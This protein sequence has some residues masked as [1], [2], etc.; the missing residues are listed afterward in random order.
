MRLLREVR[1]RGA[2]HP[3]ILNCLQLAGGTQICK[4]LV[5]AGDKRVALLEQQAELLATGLSFELPNDLALG[6]F[7]GG[8]V[9]RGREVNDQPVNLAIL[10][11][12]LGIISVIEHLHIVIGLDHRIDELQAGGADLGSEVRVLQLRHRGRIGDR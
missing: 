9:V 1:R 10:H 2:S 6:D 11:R 7:H 5:D 8:D 12:A 3:L 4:H